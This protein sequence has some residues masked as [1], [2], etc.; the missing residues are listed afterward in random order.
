MDDGGGNSAGAAPERP[1]SGMLT[2]LEMSLPLV[3]APMAGGPTTPGMAIAP[4][5]A[6]SPRAPPMTPPVLT[7]ATAPSGA[8]EF[9]S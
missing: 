2:G 7:P 6:R 9:L 4:I 5:P 3:A 1:G 8:F